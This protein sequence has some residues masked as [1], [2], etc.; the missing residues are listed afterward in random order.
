MKINIKSGIG[1]LLAAMLLVSM[2]FVPTVSAKEVN[3]FDGGGISVSK[4]VSK[5]DILLNESDIG[6]RSLSNPNPSTVG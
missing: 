3:N 2:A 6:I 5:P 1:A 4:H